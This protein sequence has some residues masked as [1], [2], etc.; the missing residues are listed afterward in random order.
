MNGWLEEASSQWTGLLLLRP[1][2]TLNC[3]PLLEISAPV[4]VLLDGS[5]QAYGNAYAILYVSFVCVLLNVYI[6]LYTPASHTFQCNFVNL[7]FYTF[8]TLYIHMHL[9]FGSPFNLLCPWAVAYTCITIIVSCVVCC[10]MFGYFL[11]YRV[12]SPTCCYYTSF[13]YGF[14]PMLILFIPAWGFPLVWVG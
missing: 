14:F 12:C 9:A 4:S 10:T 8:M 2:I 5:L 13:H 11:L 3:P 6:V 7:C 1:Y